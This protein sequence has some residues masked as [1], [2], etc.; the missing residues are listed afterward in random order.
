MIFTA[1]PTL[2][3]FYAIELFI[4]QTKSCMMTKLNKKNTNAFLH[5]NIFNEW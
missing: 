2:H 4:I 3:H 5:L 1:R